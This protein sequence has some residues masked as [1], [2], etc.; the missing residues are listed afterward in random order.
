[1][2]L[3]ILLLACADE[4]RE[5]QVTGVDGIPQITWTGASA[6]L[7]R[8]SAVDG[9]ELWAIEP[10]EATKCTNP[11]GGRQGVLWGELP[12]D[13][14]SFDEDGEVLEAEASLEDG[15]Y[16]VGVAVCTE[17]T[18]FGGSYENRGA[19]FVITDGLVSQLVPD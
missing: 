5:V 10:L 16:S 4:V 18:E 12:E 6:E 13:Y 1:M 8:F 2:I 9:T 7:L 15:S 17:F 19:S 14:G 3:S 11:L